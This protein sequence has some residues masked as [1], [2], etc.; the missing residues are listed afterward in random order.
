MKNKLY[1]PEEDRRIRQLFDGGLKD[2]E[3]GEAI[4][5]PARS[6]R[7]RRQRLRIVRYVHGGKTKTKTITLSEDR[8]RINAATAS[9]T[10]FLN[11]LR[12][13]HPEGYPDGPVRQVRRQ[14]FT[15][16]HSYSLIGS[17]MS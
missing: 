1:T 15:H 11:R 14:H 5:R 3:I 4:G 10:M 6:V 2:D 8:Q 17:S 12:E 9:T 13:V 16:Q 7:L